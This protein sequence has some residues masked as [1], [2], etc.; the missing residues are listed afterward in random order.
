MEASR[1]EMIAPLDEG[2]LMSRKGLL[3][4]E[5]FIHPLDAC[6]S[7]AMIGRQ[8]QDDE[9]PSVAAKKFW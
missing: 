4:N 7:E 3:M 8:R 9:R 2:P 6:A 5:L 1:L